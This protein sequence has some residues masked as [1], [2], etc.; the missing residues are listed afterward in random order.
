MSCAYAA[1]A[2]KRKQSRKE[3]FLIEMDRIV[4][5]IGLIAL[6]EPHYRKAK[7]GRPTYPLIAM[8][9]VQLMQNWFG[10]M[11]GGDG[12]VPLRNHAF[13]LACRAAFGSDSR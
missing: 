1:Y 9:L 4:S 5:W 12:R 6:I 7:G 3:L 10:Y 8:L 11:G 2:G 13:K